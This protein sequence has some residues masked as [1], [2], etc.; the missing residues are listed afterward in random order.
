MVE[1]L[2][3]MQKLF[4]DDRICMNNMKL[5]HSYDYVMDS[6]YSDGSSSV[7]WNTCACDAMIASIPCGL[8]I[9]PG[10]ISTWC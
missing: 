6:M 10:I 7:T 8:W 1:C 2:C 9:E 4:Q 5:W 3:E